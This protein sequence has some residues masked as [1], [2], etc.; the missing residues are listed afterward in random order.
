MES[1]SE[2]ELY[3]S[4]DL[5]FPETLGDIVGKVDDSNHFIKLYNYE[6]HDAKASPNGKVTGRGLLLNTCKNI[7]VVDVDIH[8]QLER[9]EREKIYSNY[10][11]K[12][13]SDDIVVKTG[14][15]GLHIYC[16]CDSA[17]FEAYN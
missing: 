11:N 1:S 3:S 9:A 15:N 13:T 8:K 6:K 12:L 2:L 17:D 5:D 16:A 7:C 4:I 14:N 10:L